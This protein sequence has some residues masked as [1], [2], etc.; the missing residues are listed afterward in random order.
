MDQNQ[1]ALEV[2]RERIRSWN[3]SKEEW[4]I[5]T[6][7]NEGFR[8]AHPN[9]WMRFWAYDIS[10]IDG[11]ESSFPELQL[12]EAR[13]VWTAMEE[14][15][16]ARYEY[17]LRVWP[18]WG[19]SGI[20][21]PPYPG[22]RHVGGNLGEY[23]ELGLSADLQRRFHD[24]QEEYWD[25]E[26]WSKDNKFDYERCDRIAD[27]LARDLK[28][29]VGPSIYVEREELVEVLI[30]GSTLDCRPRLGLPPGCVERQNSR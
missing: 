8:P 1:H 10:R 15:F 5:R 3:L 4:A 22:S 7:A 26:P 30:D 28:P 12:P 16:F 25:N 20:W 2:R 9:E 29:E 11:F 21:F 27:E 19:S 14:Q 13:Q 18:E 24:W 6:R 17:F 23:D